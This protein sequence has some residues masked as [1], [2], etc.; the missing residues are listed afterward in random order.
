MLPNAMIDYVVLRNFGEEQEG[1][2]NQHG[3][4]EE[5]GGRP[6]QVGGPIHLGVGHLGL[7]EQSAPN[8]RP[9]YKRAPFSAIHISMER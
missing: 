3:Q 9:G 8:R 4:G 7:Q 2:R 1:L 5:R 6:N